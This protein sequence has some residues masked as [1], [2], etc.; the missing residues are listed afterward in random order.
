MCIRDSFRTITY[1]ADGDGDGADVVLAD[2]PQIYFSNVDGFPLVNPWRKDYVFVGWT[3]KEEVVGLTTPKLDVTVQWNQKFGTESDFVNRTYVANWKP[4]TYNVFWLNWDGALPVSYTHLD[5]YKRQHL[6]QP[7]PSTVARK[8]Q[9]I[10]PR[11]S[12]GFFLLQV[13]ICFI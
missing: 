7:F 9:E 5:V 6:T 3:C 12:A 11:S 4:V 13:T 10:H 2:N 1:V 8:A